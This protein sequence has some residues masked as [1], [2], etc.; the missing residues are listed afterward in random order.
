[1]RKCP[2]KAITILEDYAEIVDEMCIKCGE[3]QEI[4][5]QNA[6]TIISDIDRVKMAISSE[7]KVLVSL[8]PSFVGAFDLDDA[9][10]IVTGLKL[11]GFDVVEETAIGAEIVSD[12]YKKQIEKGDKKNLITTSCPSANYMIE[13]YYPELVKYM[14]PVV[15][16]MLAHGKIMKHH[17]GM[18]N[19]MVFIGPCLA[20]KAEAE[21]PEHR[22]LIDS[23][24]TFEELSEWFSEDNIDL[25]KLNITDFDKASYH[26]GRAFPI[27]GG[28]INEEVKKAAKDKYE[29]IR[30]DGVDRCK[31]I[32]DALKNEDITKSCIEINVCMGSCVDGP[33]MPKNK[34]N[35]YVRERRVREYV[36]KEQD[37]WKVNAEL[38]TKEQKEMDYRK[39]F[40]DRKVIRREASESEITAILRKM[41]KFRPED[42]LNCN[43]CGYLTCREKAQAVYEGMSDITMC[44]PYMRA[45]AESLR[46]IIFGRS[47]N[48]ILMLDEE[49]FVKEINP[50]GEELFNVQAEDLV[51]KPISMIID[52]SDFAKVI[53][54]GKNIIS[55]K[56]EFAN[57][58]AVIY[59]NIIYIEKEGIVL[60]ILTDVTQE[61]KSRKELARVKETTIN[62]AQEVIEKQMRVAQEIASLLGE[63]TAET[64]V[65]LTKLKNITLGEA[66]E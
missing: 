52:D 28:L 61:E 8:A 7:K 5:P 10:Q 47:P 26:R 24:L 30:V 27:G 51:G 39:L 65:I 55:E 21:E 41:G 25:K 49:L 18:D 63:T 43:A 19:Y 56:K 50:A 36:E 37:Y 33:G 15:S 4:C 66:G 23:V 2:S 13:R 22:T 29:I 34:D 60:A 20:K 44:L 1:L 64:K 35:Y 6:L 31:D 57:Y 54:S 14:M 59:Q 45:K 9:R 16:P 11:L 40:I 53:E 46:N 48:V 58:G 42:E 3:C 62:S 12:Y 32:L 17:Y 38:F